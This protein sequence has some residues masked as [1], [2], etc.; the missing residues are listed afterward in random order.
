MRGNSRRSEIENEIWAPIKNYPD[1]AVSNYGRVFNLTHDR[2]VKGRP[3]PYGGLRVSLSRGGEVT[4]FYIHHLVAQAFMSG[5]RPTIHI[6]HRDGDKTNNYH[7]N[8]KFG[9]NRGL[10]QYRHDQPDVHYRRVMI[11]ETGEVFRTVRDCARYLKTQPSSI[12]K[13]LRGERDTHLGYTFKY[14]EEPV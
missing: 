6:S 5:W 2:E 9:N 1:Y 14:H 4:D 13:V 8:L 12:Y 3:S 10:G 7:L 11:V